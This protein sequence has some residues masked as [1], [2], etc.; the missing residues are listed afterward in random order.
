MKTPLL[1]GGYRGD[2]QILTDEGISI[3]PLG[4]W[5]YIVSEK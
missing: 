2:Y 5:L 4:F 1:E 3:T